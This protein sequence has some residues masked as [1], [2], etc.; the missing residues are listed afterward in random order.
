MILPLSATATRRD[1]EP[2][3][4]L[5]LATWAV[6]DVTVVEVSGELDV[7]AADRLAHYL[8][9]EITD[10]DSVVVDLCLC[11]YLNLACL[12]VIIGAWKRAEAA[13]G[14][15]DVA[16]TSDGQVPAVFRRTGL[17]AIFTLHHTVMDAVRAAS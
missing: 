7:Y 10:G 6:S 17:T 15:L 8:R 13:G 1:P 9:E 16:C 14:S 12:G 3:P 11:G 4:V 5:S 2:A